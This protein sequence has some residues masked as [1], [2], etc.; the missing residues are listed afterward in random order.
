[1]VTK[2]RSSSSKIFDLLRGFSLVLIVFFLSACISTRENAVSPP[3]QQKAENEAFLEKH[4]QRPLGSQG[5]VPISLNP[6]TCQ[7]CHASQYA[8][9]RQSLHAHAMGPG[10]LGQFAD[11]RANAAE[12]HQACLRCH[13]PLSEQAEALAK[14][15]HKKTPLDRGLQSEG[16]ICAGCHVR[17]GKWY[18]PPRVDGS[19]LEKNLAQY[20]PHGGWNA[21]P[22]FESSQFCAACH[23]FNKDD[24]ALN[25]KLLENTFE[26]WQASRY[27]RE[28]QSCQSC[29]MPE[30]RHLFR[31]I[32]D[33]E[34]TRRAL[35]IYES[36]PVVENGKVR[37]KLS[38]ENT[39]AG[40]SFPTYVTPRVLL[41]IFQEDDKGH[42]LARS[43]RQY[44]IN[45]EVSLDVS[46]E[47]SDT[48]LAPGARAE[49]AYDAALE[50][51]AA[52]L[53]FRV[54]VEPDNFYAKFYRARLKSKGVK[55][56]RKALEVAL[57]NAETSPYTLYQSRQKL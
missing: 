13:A 52:Q 31:G 50:K 30:R 6:T 57:K 40:H 2:P 26:E 29:H 53:V 17:N 37:A 10:I 21:A 11:M 34:M 9:W 44:V 18:G 41:E 16:L 42:E 43:R 19:R 54:R 20:Y 1:M 28:G 14:A 39:G 36:P 55:Q 25:G 3:Q 23:Q 33:S 12:D 15:L 8:D 46:K 49:L 32:H 45:R 27:A 56:G 47:I 51:Q 38:V 4:W 7:Q 48:R 35:T 24:Y 22:A 5:A